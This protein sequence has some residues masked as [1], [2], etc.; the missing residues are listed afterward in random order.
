MATE[1][2]TKTSQGPEIH[3]NHGQTPAAW[4]AVLIILVAFIVGTV[5]VVIG[6]WP[7]FWVGGVALATI[8]VITGRVMSMMGMGTKPKSS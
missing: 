3:L 6:S 8:G 4:T 2:V 7:L 1:G 5:G